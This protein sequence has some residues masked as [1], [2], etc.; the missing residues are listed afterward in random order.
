MLA[1]VVRRFGGAESFQFQ[2]LVVLLGMAGLAALLL[3][4]RLRQRIQA[5]VGRHFR[6]AQHDSVR[7]LDGVLAAAGATCKDQA[8]LCAASARLVSETFE[9]LS[10]TVWLL[11]EQRERLRA[12]RVHR[13][14][15]AGGPDATPSRVGRPCAGLRGEPAPFDLDEVSEPW[16][17]ELRQ[18]E[19]VDVPERRRTA[20]ACRCGPASSA[21]ARSSWPTG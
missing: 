1:Q 18:A 5:F 6:K 3:S 11:D 16:A 7:H 9:V 13:P 10:V 8:G 4:D 15:Q 21:W 19:P 20:G 2:A 12:L 14:A 17:E